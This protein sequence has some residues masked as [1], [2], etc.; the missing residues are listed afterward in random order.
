MRQHKGVE[1]AW[2]VGSC[3]R[4]EVKVWGKIFPG[5]GSNWLEG[6]GGVGQHGQEEGRWKRIS[7][8]QA[9]ART[10]TKPLTLGFPVCDPGVVTVELLCR[11]AVRIRRHTQS[12]QLQATLGK[13]SAVYSVGHVSQQPPDF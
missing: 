4:Q 9:G 5:R 13:C 6:P 2:R 3:P 7:R 1:S 11:A 12:T 8:R 10:V